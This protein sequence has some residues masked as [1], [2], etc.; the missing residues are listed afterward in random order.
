[1][2]APGHDGPAGQGPVQG[3]APVHH[4]AVL[5]GVL[6]GPEVRRSLGVQ[7][8]IGDLV[9]QAEPVAERLQ[10]VH[11]HLL[12]LMGGVAALEARAEGPALDGLGQDHRR[13]P[14]LF[15][16]GLVGGVELPVVVAAPGEVAD[17]VVG[18]VGRQLAQAGIR[19]EEV[20][21]GEGAVL[22]GVAL[23]GAVDG[24]VHLVDQ[25]AVDVAGQQLVPT[26]AP[27]D[28]DDVPARA[29]E[30]GLELLDDLPVAPH[31]AVEA[32]EVAVDDP[33]QVVQALPG[34]QGD[35]AQ[36]L[37][38]V[39]L[40]VAHEAPD[41]GPAGV[42]DLAVLEVAQEPGL[43]ERVRAGRGPSTPSGTPRTRA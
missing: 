11:G 34:G 16:R 25:D 5:D 24:L 14:G 20:L 22:H 6:G 21:A 10:L 39:D 43:V 37:G 23:V 40:A 3:P 26:A 41:P 12:D 19:A 9:V 17:V 36:G 28:L 29:P 2:R 15:G 33:G 8:V 38:L 4:V 42:V 30:D 13:G 31:R 18:E 7:G 1:M 32:L 27:D 35:G